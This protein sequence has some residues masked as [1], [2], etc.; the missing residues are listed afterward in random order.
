MKIS[1]LSKNTLFKK[2]FASTLLAS[3]IPI[4]I[5]WVY[6]SIR[7]GNM[8]GYNSNLPFLF[9]GL[10]LV[11]IVS[12]GLNAFLFSRHYTKPVTSFIA[13]ATEI[14]RGNFSE[15]VE[16][17][18]KDEIGKLAKIF[19]YMVTELRRLDEMNLNKI[20]N[21][22]DKTEAILKNIADGVIVT[23]GNSRVLLT[24]YVA[25]N[26]FALQ[27]KDFEGKQIE[28]VVANEPLIGFI[29]NIV[30]NKDD[31]IENMEIPLSEYEPGRKRVLQAN[32]ARVIDREK[33]SI[34]AVVTVLRDITHE[35]EIDRMK[36]ELVSMVAHEL[37][38]PLTCIS[39]F[40]ELLL[41]STVTRKQSEEYASIIMKESNRL[42]ELIN[43][44]LDISKIEAGK[45]QIRKV[46]VDLIMLIEKV[47]DFNSQLA[48]KKKIEVS[49]DKPFQMPLIDL[50]RDMMEQVILNLFSNAVK[51]S[52][53]QAQVHL[54][55]VEQEEKILIQVQDTG[56]GISQQ[57][58]E[59]VF[60]KFYRVTDNE[61][62]RE[63]M[64]SGL[65]LPL[66]KEIVE[67]HGGNIEVSSVLDEGSTF[68]IRLPKRLSVVEE[69]SVEDAIGDNGV[70]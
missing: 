59:H 39:G 69:E 18:S 37:R 11:V 48:D 31:K 6:F 5:T 8:V 22:R 9:Y 50:D 29:N 28:S 54:R 23:D 55:L 52:P 53:E 12:V 65:G 44:F 16:V 26:W 10:S 41:D 63:I 56:Y 36:T 70:C 27:D 4:G 64:G 14:A 35:K 61:A 15:K 40:S 46:P 25:E 66:V 3:F 49:F 7:N 60:D 17:K 13:T 42:N 1:F 2:L 34:S 43:K 62:V 38:S 57:S 21:E 19:N 45:S 20:I 67:V 30:S 24:N 33:K 47:L 68:T 51:Y 32:A 58:L